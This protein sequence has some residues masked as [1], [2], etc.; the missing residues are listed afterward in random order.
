ML[1]LNINYE[2]RADRI[3]TIRL[4]DTVR[5]GRHELVIVLDEE[6]LPRVESSAQAELLMQF[7]GTVAAFSSVDGVEFQREARSEWS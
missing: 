5:P 7:A 2:V 4:P 6:S 3:V 1:T